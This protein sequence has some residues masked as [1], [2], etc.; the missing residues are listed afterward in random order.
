MT[1]LGTSCP[2]TR[3]HRPALATLPLAALL[4]TWCLPSTTLRGQ[5]PPGPADGVFERQVRPILA[6]KCH[7]CHGPQMQ[8]SSLNLSTPE[9]IRRGGESGPILDDK[10][11][12]ESTIYKYVRERI[13]PPE[14]EGELA[15]EE[16][17]TISRWIE[18]GARLGDAAA[19]SAAR[20]T[21]HDALPI[22]LLHCAACHGRH[23][24]EGGLDVRS[25]AALAKGG[26]SGPAIVPGKPEESLLVKRIRAAEMPPLKKLASY[27]VKPVTPDELDTLSRWIAGGAPEVDVPADVA[28]TEPDPLVSDDDRQFWAFRPPRLPEVPKVAAADRALNP[29]DAFLLA[30]LEPRG[31]ALAPPADRRTLIR[32]VYFDLLGLPPD[33]AEIDAFV[34]DARDDAYERLV[35]RALASPRYGERWGQYWLDLAGYADSEG[36]TNADDVR[37]HNWRYRDYVIR[38]FNDDKPYD[39]FLVEQL[40]GDEL[41]D[42]E[43]A[44]EITPQIYDNLVATG[45]LRQAPDGTFASITSFVPDRLDLIDDEIEVFSS[46]VLGLTIKCARCHSHKSDPIPQRDYYRLAAVFKGALDEHDW[47]A[48]RLGGPQQP[49]DAA[50]C[51]LP[52][53]TTAERATWQAAGAKKEDQPLI[54]AVFDLGEPSPTYILRRGNYLARGPLV[55]P[56]VPSVLTDGRTPLDIR[57]PWPAAKKTGRRLALARWVTQKDQPLTAR[58]MVNR[59]WKHHFGEG[60]V[61][62]LDNFGKVG[63]PPTHPELLDWLAI[64]FVEH[65]WSVK[66]LH[67]VMMNSAAYRQSSQVS[68]DHERLDPENLLV[69]RMP[70]RR[71]EGEVLRDSLLY[72]S[73]RLDLTPFGKPDALEVRS[74][75]SIAV[76]AGTSQ[77]WRRSIYALKRRTQPLTILQ[78][79]DVAAMDPNCILRRESIVAPQALHLANDALVRELARSLAARIAGEAGD[80]LPRQVVVAYRIAAGRDPTDEEQQIALASL[81]ELES[82]WAA[83]GNNKSTSGESPDPRRLALENLC[84]ALFNSAAFL[85]ID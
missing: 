56:G 73:G 18:A 46:A 84:H 1:R 60:I 52:H 49:A 25:V 32:R 82:A 48:P 66:E 3:D 83:Q 4:L 21:Q 69:S 68:Q 33:P 72:V 65:R 44:A 17:A 42:Y 36:F 45:F 15:D 2:T 5:Q 59:V 76:Q 7:K 77:R 29:V 40:A 51:L 24:R 16:I 75:G 38:A 37:P 74:D 11:P 57:P 61:R 63:A 78:G 54:R 50:T 79:F 34:A 10:H 64:Y 27:S 6:A 41:C 9:G 67:R 47:L 14:G 8:K 23:R 35:D 19:E 71:M 85:Y 58:V 70:L 20:I 22:L 62:S 13:M 53:V 81:G 80:D 43:S 39:R 31:L 12:T 26:K 30:K 28:T 55:A